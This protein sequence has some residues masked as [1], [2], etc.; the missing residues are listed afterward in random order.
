MNPST[1]ASRAR[2]TARLRAYYELTKPGITG[3]VMISAGVAAYVAAKGQLDMAVAIFTMVGTGLATAGAL[4]LNQYVERAVDGIMLRTL[5]RPLPSGRLQPVECLVFGIVLLFS[6]LVGLGVLVHWLPAALAA[7]SAAAYHLVYT[8]LKTRHHL[9]TIAGGVPGALPMLIGWTAVTGKVD[10][11]GLA[12][13]AIGYAWQLP[14]VLG[15][16]W[17]LREDHA[18]VGFKLIPS[19]DTGGK[20]IGRHMVAWLIA[21]IVVSGGPTYLGLTGSI[22]LIGALTLSVVYLIVGMGAA[23]DLTDKAARK[24]FFG[25]LLYH[26][27]LLVLMLIDT[28][29]L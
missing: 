12:M 23:R 27:V 5:D 11:G 9:A 14:H 4:A 17:M 10:S 25:S 2:G 26:P 22:Y 8:P 29:R 6:G 3:Y 15:L 16:A 1:T 13:F 24:V 18:R 7:V 20:T 21:L 28:V 19:G